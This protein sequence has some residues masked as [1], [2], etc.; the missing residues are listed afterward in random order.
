MGSKEGK[1]KSKSQG[2]LTKG[3]FIDPYEILAVQKGASAK[4]I[5]KA[6]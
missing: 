5:K 1:E 4:E 6:W 2:N 3:T